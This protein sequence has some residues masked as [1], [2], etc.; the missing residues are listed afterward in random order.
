M[1]V[2]RKIEWLRSFE[3]LLLLCFLFGIHNVSLAQYMVPQTG[4]NTVTTCFGTLYDAGGAAGDY[5]NNSNGYTIIKP[6]QR[7]YVISV[8]GTLWTEDRSSYKDYLEIYDGAGISGTP[9][10]T[11]YSPGHGTPFTIPYLTATNPDG[12]LTIRFVSD[13]DN[14]SHGF[15]L[16]INCDGEPIYDPE[17]EEPEGYCINIQNLDTAGV[18]C[19]YGTF[20]DPYANTGHVNGR[21]TVITDVHAKDVN[22]LLYKVCPGEAA[23]VQLGN[24]ATGAQA[25]AVEYDYYVNTNAY[26]I[27]ILKYA[28]VLEDPDPKHSPDK[29]PRFTF[30]LYDST[31]QH[32]LDATC[33][34]A[35]FIAGDNTNGWK[36]AS[37]NGH[38]IYYK[39]WTSVG[40]DLSAYNHQN[41]KIKLTTYDCGEGTHY[42]YA[43][44]SL[45]CAHKVITRESCGDITQNISAYTAPD[46]FVYKWYYL[47]DPG[48]VLST[49]QTDTVRPEDLAGGDSRTL[50][51]DVAFV[52]D[53]S[54]KFTLSA[55]VRSRY[56]VADFSV[57]RQKCTYMVWLENNSY[58]TSDPDAKP[59]D[60][61]D[62]CE[63]A[64]WDFGDGVVT[65]SYNPV[66]HIYSQPGT[67]TITLVSSVVHGECQDTMRKTVE[68]FPDT[69]H[70]LFTD[71]ICLGDTLLL[72]STAPGQYLWSTGD[73]ANSLIVNQEANVAVYTAES[74]YDDCKAYDTAT[75]TVQYRPVEDLEHTIVDDETYYYAPDVLASAGV[76]AYHYESI[77]E[78]DSLVNLKLNH[79]VH[80][81]VSLCPGEIYQFGDR[82][83]STSGIYYD[84][85]KVRGADSITILNAI[86]PDPY[87]TQE[88]ATLCDYDSLLWHDTMLVNLPANTYNIYDT[89][90]SSNGCDSVCLLVLTV[91][92]HSVSSTTLKGICQ[93]K[94]YTWNGMVYDSTGTYSYWQNGTPCNKERRLVLTVLPTYDFK[95]TLYICEN[96]TVYWHGQMIV[97]DG[98]FSDN[99]H[100][101][102]ITIGNSSCSCD[103][104]YHL[105]V[106]TNPTYWLTTDTM[107][108][109][110]E[111][112]HWR[113]RDYTESDTVVEYLHT[114]YTN[115]DSVYELRLKVL[116][117]YLTQEADT[118]CEDDV[119]EWHSLHLTE[120]NTYYDTIRYP[121][122]CD[123]LIY[124]LDLTVNKKTTSILDSTICENSLPFDWNHR[125]FETAG[126]LYDTLVNSTGCDSL[127]T[128]H[129]HVD[130]NTH[131]ILYDT[132]CENLLPYTWNDSVFTQAGTIVTLISNGNGCD[133]VV[134]M[135]LHVDTNTH[136]V[137]YDTICENDLPFVWNHRTFTA[138]GTLYDT[139]ANAKGCD[140]L[141]TM[142]LHVDTNTHSV[143]YDTV[144]EN[145]LPYVWNHRTFTAAG[146]L[147]DTLVNAKGCDSLVTMH[148]YVD[149]NTHSVLYDT[150]CENS[151]PY[152]WN[153]RTFTVAGTL[154]D[155]L[156]NAKGCDSLVTM[157]LYVDTNTHSDLY[158][159]ICENF[160]PYSWNNRTFTMG[161]TLYDTLVNAT[162]CDSLITM[163]LHVD[164][165]THSVLYDTICENFLPYS[166][167]NRTF[168]MGG[169]LYDTLVNATGCDSLIT[170]NLHVDTN[171]HS[172]LY[173]TICEN[174]LPYSWNSRVFV[175]GG[176]LYDTLA[177]AKGCDSLITMNLHVDTNTHSTIVETIVENQL[178][179]TFNGYI[180]N[181][182]ISNTLVTIVNDRGCDSLIDY[183]LIVSWNLAVTLDSTICYS[184]LPLIWNS[185]TFT[186]AGTQM[187]TL[188]SSTGSDSVLTMNLYV[189]PIYDFYDT[190]EICDNQSY[191]WRG[192]V[193]TQPGDYFD[194]LVSSLGCDS[195]YHF[196]LIVHPTYW[197][198][199]TMTICDNQSY[200]WHGQDYVNQGNYYDSLFTQYGC[201]SVYQLTLYVQPTYWFYD[202]ATICDNQSYVWHGTAYTQPGIYYDSLL[203]Q[204]GCD[205]VYQ[206]KLYVNPTY[207]Y[208]DT[209]EICDNETQ[210]WHG[211][212]YST[213]GIYYDSLLTQYG[214]DSVYQLNLIVHQTYFFIDSILLCQAEP[215]LNWHGEIYTQWGTYYDSLQSQHGC[216]SIWQLVFLVGVPDTIYLDRHI[217]Q[218]DT[219]EDTSF[220]VATDVVGTFHY[221]ESFI[222]QYG[223]DSTVYLQLTVHPTY[224]VQ[225]WDTICQYDPYT[226][227][228]FDLQDIN[229]PGDYEYSL[230]LQTIYGCDSILYLSL[231]VK[232]TYY[233]DFDESICQGYVYRD[234]G[235]YLGIQEELGHFTHQQF[236]LTEEGCDSIITLNL[237][238]VEPV[239]HVT[240]TDG[241]LCEEGFVELSAAT[242]MSG[243]IWSTGDTGKTLVVTAPGRYYAYAD[244][245]IC[246]ASDFI[247]VAP[248]KLDLYIPNA[249]TPSKDEGINDYF[250]V[251]FPEFYEVNK[252]EIYI[253][254]RWGKL[255][256]ESDDTNFKW[257]GRVDGKLIPNN[258][259]VYKIYV[260]GK[261]GFEYVFKGTITVL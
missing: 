210:S 21:H 109:A 187:D 108:C 81:N 93:G 248:C 153:N 18:T 7:G 123:S 116:P 39:D 73:T 171:T 11:G 207:W 119:Y 238:V 85:V 162:G 114:Q 154:L 56:P 122:G 179:W 26:D 172:I 243:F 107:I 95:D 45:S 216:D 120:T 195:I 19:Y 182:S 165:N 97:H 3:V 161:G 173:D 144:C 125:R 115:C 146:T 186:S 234:H 72:Q 139:L 231:H 235:F 245:G 54:C 46:G 198:Y 152:V 23:S 66:S 212:V 53:T 57:G 155:T 145:F 105:K 164:T 241:D 9:I 8:Y 240:Q 33:L 22:N 196:H 40:V 218:G 157:H 86:I 70:I 156:V 68:L 151:L 239:V 104:I 84:T 61:E 62:K 191:T 28:A 141:I 174:F 58:T 181:D 204:Y 244:E 127:V 92:A 242:D 223:C 136:S 228:S 135:V 178:P 168:T 129:L 197:F 78:C 232:P 254:D 24:S 126:T 250:Y 83:I 246:T 10:W 221:A 71:N 63:E 34:A 247:N 75:V 149:T 160:L 2:I 32:L 177:N 219:Y 249:I 217:C 55:Q 77:Y 147:L 82:T 1:A 128:M 89:L 130:T 48:N 41:I 230:N 259:F 142:N 87:F 60:V 38:F 256:F 166:W 31:G 51:C 79:V 185:R 96:D 20:N 29:R 80:Q 202:T 255:A 261:D 199:D 47:D 14:T 106:Y 211:N 132:I 224:S 233:I 50:C 64:Y 13:G 12:V 176:T 69:M 98:D 124:Q 131:S 205:S 203:T 209:L 117:Q 67:Y 65:Y 258:V 30:A 226:S 148:L 112:L 143:L 27:L 194:S 183:T 111:T 222:N 189:N 59:H 42:G 159:T 43:Y 169:T 52:D 138:G 15:E 252:F 17:P 253:Y 167:N 163:N 88:V 113:G 101:Q 170:M 190:T 175:A 220:T 208:Y 102:P 35:D 158:D 229:E 94:T 225:L 133:S 25:E 260:L 121:N 134:T 236:L 215:V 257:D 4:S 193:Y 100:T 36:F 237:W 188:I 16:T 150:V 110:G 140:S 137:L 5:L 74:I 91:T 214:C 37:V 192:N 200:N 99:L 118:I 6:V 180:F 44:Y 227:N 103:S 213:P 206:L 49:M 76:Y 184:E 251:V 201:D 90:V